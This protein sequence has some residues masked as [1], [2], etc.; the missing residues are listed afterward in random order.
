MARGFRV[1][2]GDLFR[3]PPPRFLRDEGRTV[4]AGFGMQQRS[5]VAAAETAALRGG[6]LDDFGEFFKL[7]IW[8]RAINFIGR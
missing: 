8:R 4:W 3:N 1:E 5:D 2:N 6:E 7:V